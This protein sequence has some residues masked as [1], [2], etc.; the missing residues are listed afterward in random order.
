[1]TKYFYFHNSQW[2]PVEVLDY[3]N[4]KDLLRLVK[5][6]IF[7]VREPVWVFAHLLVT[8]KELAEIMGELE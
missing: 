6:K 2:T 4:E 7:G 3:G 1:M 5:V 8:S